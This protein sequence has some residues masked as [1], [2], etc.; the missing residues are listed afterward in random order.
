[1]GWSSS[2]IALLAGFLAVVGL[3]LGMIIGHFGITTNTQTSQ[4][5]PTEDLSVID[6]L[7]NEI[8]AERIRENLR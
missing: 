2:R 8:S 1:M 7:M 5:A 6:K 4:S 3:G